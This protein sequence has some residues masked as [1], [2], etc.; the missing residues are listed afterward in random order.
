[1]ETE[2]G[3]RNRGKRRETG[4]RQKK[5]MDGRGTE[6]GV[7]RQRQEARKQEQEVRKQGKDARNQGKD[8]RKQ[9]SGRETKAGNM[10]AGTGGKNRDR[11]QRNRGGGKETMT[12]GKKTGTGGKETGQTFAISFGPKR[13]RFVCLLILLLWRR[14]KQHNQT[15]RRAVEYCM[16]I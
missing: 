6:E 8:A 10:L 3:L 1:L 15:E 11:R 12:R 2:P 7:R 14:H 13:R 16:Y 9:G 5:N 4:R